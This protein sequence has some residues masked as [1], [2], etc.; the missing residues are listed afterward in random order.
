MV[1]KPP[2]GENNIRAADGSRPT[3]NKPHRLPGALRSPGRRPS[4][5]SG[6]AGPAQGLH[7]RTPRR[8]A[9]H[10]PRP[11]RKSPR[12][13]PTRP[14]EEPPRPSSPPA[15][16]ERHPRAGAERAQGLLSRD[17]APHRIPADAEHHP[18]ESWE[19]TGGGGA[20]RDEWAGPAR[21]AGP[22]DAGGRGRETC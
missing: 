21:G 1:T 5:G 13:G 8:R 9:A 19:F 6:P 12:P 16:T 4:L 10:P 17:L 18:Q 20:G 7:S 11:L 3:A 2:A 22:P 15:P 14:P